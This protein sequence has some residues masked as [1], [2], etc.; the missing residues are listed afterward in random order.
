MRNVVLEAPIRGEL[1]M[2]RHSPSGRLYR[3]VKGLWAWFRNRGL[4][5]ITQSAIDRIREALPATPYIV[6]LLQFIEASKRG[7]CSRPVIGSTFTTSVRSR[8]S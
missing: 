3:T 5:D 7:I 1:T 4:R 8:R 2:M 6:R